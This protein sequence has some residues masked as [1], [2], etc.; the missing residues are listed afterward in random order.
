MALSK[1][2]IKKY[3]NSLKFEYTKGSEKGIVIRVK[4]YRHDRNDNIVGTLSI[5]T[6][7]DDLFTP[8]KGID[9][10]LN[11]LR[12]RSSF[13]NDLVKLDK[14]ERDDTFWNSLIND[15]SNR[16]LYRYRPQLEIEEILT[17]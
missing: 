9:L 14:S 4:N 16:T 8:I 5:N 10:R 12:S 7:D 2:V 13:V 3:T 6:S 11:S 15:I 17:I 1:P